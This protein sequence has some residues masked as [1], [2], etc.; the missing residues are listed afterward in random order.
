VL[1]CSLLEK[2]PA[3]RLGHAFDVAAALSALSPSI[4]RSVSRP[5]APV[6][7]RPRMVGRA[8]EQSQFSAYLRDAADGR[9][10][11]GLIAGE[12]GIGK[13]FLTTELCR[14]AVIE[15]FQVV[16]GE[17]LPL[18][19]A[20]GGPGGAPL[21]AF[22]PFLELVSDSC[23]EPGNEALASSL[24][25]EL[26]AL[27]PFEPSLLGLLDT[28]VPALPAFASR[29][30]VIRA[31]TDLV[32]TW[33]A[34]EPLLLA[35]DDLQ[36]A[37]D[38]SLAALDLLSDESVEGRRLLVVGTYRSDEAV[39]G[40]A[41]IAAKPWVRHTTL[42]RLS[43]AEVSDIVSGLLA[44]HEP[45]PSVV[46]FVHHHSE[47]VPFFVAEYVRALAAEGLLHRAQGRWLLGV[48]EHDGHAAFAAVSFPTELA[49]LVQRR[50]S[51][52][53]P[54]L[55]ELLECAAV[56]GRNF[57]VEVLAHAL[58]V[59]VALLRERLSDLELRHVLA[60]VSSD[61]YRFLHDKIRESVYA[62]IAR[63]RRQRLHLLAALA[64]EAQRCSDAYP[65][66]AHHYREA[67][68]VARAI[69]CFEAA[70]AQA[71]QLS[72]AADALRDLRELSALAQRLSPPPAALRRARWERMT[73]DAY[74]GLGCMRESE[75]PLARA[76]ELLGC[77]VPEHD[78]LI[79]ARLVPEIAR[80]VARRLRAQRAREPQDR[81][82]L[83]ER[84]RVFDRLQRVYYF[85]G[86]DS[87]L[88]L[89]TVSSL[90]ASQLPTP[91]LAIAF[92]FA[93]AVMDIFVH[94]H[95]LAELYFRLGRELLPQIQD[96]GAES[97]LHMLFALYHLGHGRFDAGVPWADKA[98][99]V[100]RSSGFF[101]R[102]AE[103]LAVRAGLELLRGQHRRVQPYLR[104]LA[105]VTSKRDDVQMLAWSA[106]QRA[107][108]SCLA[109]D[110]AAAGSLLAEI[111]T[112]EAKLSRP[113]R[114]WLHGL[115]CY[116]AYQRA[117]LG[118]AERHR[119]QG[120]ELVAVGPPCHS[121]CLDAYGKLTEVAVAL[122]ARG[123]IGR[124]SAE[125][126]CAMLD[127]AARSFPVLAPVTRLH[128][129]SLARCL[130]DGA[131]AERLLREGLLI[132]RR[133]GS[134]YEQARL[135]LALAEGLENGPE[136][137]FHETSARQ[138]SQELGTPETWPSTCRS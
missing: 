55:S 65:S 128:R 134:L 46:G 44:L 70:A 61:R 118:L 45:P 35:L 24:L 9:A 115:S 33:S 81:D 72:A 43:R 57:E 63:A 117:E 42:Q 23:R 20:G 14:A 83:I 138:I 79:G 84:G 47:G 100:A 15:G 69:E 74:Q 8:R 102:L 7:Y 48:D 113:E 78:V 30:R 53:D 106:F 10:V 108:A 40:I 92:G 77:P 133:S 104:E 25:A 127:S 112:L 132:A 94:S 64:I 1:I 3:R 80:Q 98:I 41:R 125:R 54:A 59:P 56:L 21:Q 85:K 121:G 96:A 5:A 119:A 105:E 87:A 17:C 39:D 29:E 6:L 131:R 82:L 95:K 88:L 60:G 76:A 91:E 75:A 62:G 51:G 67:G 12:S 101:R 123:A 27:S 99:D 37:D 116:V 38:L 49:Q 126:S 110:I 137:R 103:S 93:A 124:A 129:A 90:N 26:R 97:N 114:I 136:R 19:A 28:A 50:L 68:D 13:S 120:M 122:H 34:H 52:L 71:L 135:R 111:E 36:W 58:Q 18:A 73:A 22:R 89:A 11:F 16:A 109:G 2:D 4:E 66:L 32:A 31:L 130:G 86:H 107:H